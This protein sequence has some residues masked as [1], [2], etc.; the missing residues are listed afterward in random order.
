MLRRYS[1]V[2]A[3]AAAAVSCLALLPVTSAQGAVRAPW[4]TPRPG[5]TY[6]LALRFQRSAGES[7]HPR[8]HREPVTACEQKLERAQR[9]RQ[10]HDGS[11]VPALAI[12][13]ASFT[14]G[15]GPG[16]PGKS[17]A[18]VLARRL[19]WDAVIYG[20]PG[21]GYVRAGVGRR[22]R[23]P[24]RS[25]G[26]TFARSRPRSSSCRPGHDDIG[27]PLALE[28]RRVEQ[29]VALIH[30]EAPHARIALLTVFAGRSP[31]AAAYRTDH[32]IVTAGR[33]ADRNVIIIDPLAA[34]WTFPRSRDGLH[35]TAPG[36]AW[37]AGQ[38]AGSLRE[39][40][41]R[42]APRSP[43]RRARSSATGV[44]P[45]RHRGG[46]R[47]G[48][49]SA[50]LRS[51]DLAAPTRS[52]G[53]PR[54]GLVLSGRRSRIRV[55]PPGAD[56]A[57][58][59]P[60]VA[61]RHLAHDREPETRAWHGPGRRRPVEA[62]EDM[63]QVGG[64]DTRSLVAHGE[65]AAEQPYLHRG[66]RRA[67]LGRVVQQVTDRDLQPPGA[68][69]DDARLQIGRERGLRPVPPGALQACR[70]HLIEPDVAERAGDRLAAGQLGDV[71]HQLAELRRPGRRP[72]P[73]PPGALPR[74]GRD[75]RPAAR[76]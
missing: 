34:G 31:S 24:P 28:Q 70:H 10:P 14:A 11:G 46:S 19:H 33:A 40:G 4:A 65:L 60:A 64:R 26:L 43:I 73:A 62:V 5:S 18:V 72:G 2:I 47:A 39:H 44:F 71:G 37:I 63:R 41:V 8:E 51:A 16:N 9:Q 15:V 53:R 55:P 48:L 30:A 50:D 76:R 36:S 17:W 13:G 22:G 69:E 74:T 59:D 23:S 68:A 42:P 20:D 21:A 67:E 27:V 54:S 58:T 25:R 57:R 66:A 56:S 1:M 61:F 6:S 49:R 7:G 29:A 32:A 75:R 12:V 38:V 3:T 35:P 52:G 45:L